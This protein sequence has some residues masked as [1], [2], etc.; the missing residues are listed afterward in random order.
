V[1]VRRPLGQTTGEGAG[2][3]RPLRPARARAARATTYGPLLALVAA[4]LFTL[5]S[6]PAAG[7]A[8][9][10]ATDQEARIRFTLENRRLTTRVLAD[11]PRRIR[12]ELYGQRIRA[13]C[14]TNFV[15]TRGVKVR[16]ARTWPRGRRT[17]RFRFERNIS[18]RAKWCL[19]EHPR[20]GDVAFVSF[21]R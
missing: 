11:A 15:F 21:P 2:G 5:L 10:R 1:G 14:G 9:R 16:D 8:T 12:R 3:A 6:A 17:V 18:R 20:G 13:V 19:L 7:A 4:A